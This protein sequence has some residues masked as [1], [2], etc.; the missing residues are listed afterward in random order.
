[1]MT[2]NRAHRADASKADCACTTTLTADRQ[3]EPVLFVVNRVK[4]HLTADFLS[5]N[6]AV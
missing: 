6:G 3:Y 4:F 2:H 1:M 5:F